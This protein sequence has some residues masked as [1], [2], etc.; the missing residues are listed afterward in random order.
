ME[1]ESSDMPLGMKLRILRAREG[2]SQDA[3]AQRIGI[4][5][6]TLSALEHD[7]RRAYTPTLHK[8]AKGYGVPV[9]ELMEAEP[10]GPK[11]PAP[12]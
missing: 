8:I 2:W 4:T 11:A 1:L 7:Q 10:P 5:P 12:Y 9:E 6:D 3:A